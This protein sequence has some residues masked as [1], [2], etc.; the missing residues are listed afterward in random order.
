MTE[1]VIHFLGAILITYF[2]SRGFR[3]LI[4]VDQPLVRLVAP[5]LLTFATVLLML[6]ALRY[7]LFIFHKG[8]LG[9][10]AAA[11]LIWVA[12]DAFRSGLAF[13]PPVVEPTE[14]SARAPQARRP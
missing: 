9:I 11:Q 3:R 6:L 12:F 10:Y 7:P 13:R 4:R 14:P 2:L 8:Q 5:H 1:N